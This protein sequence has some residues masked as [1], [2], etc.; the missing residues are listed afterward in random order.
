LPPRRLWPR[1][2]LTAVG[3]VV[4]F[5]LFSACALTLVPAAHAA[6]IAGLLP[7]ATA[8]MAVLRS[9]ER[10]RAAFWAAAL[11]GLIAVLGF[12]A[13]QG[14]GCP[15]LADALILI[16]VLLG[17]LGYAEGGALSRELGA[18]QVISWVLV[19]S[20]PVLLPVVAWR[21]LQIGLS[22]SPAA[23][24]GFAYVS[25][26][27]M[28]LGFFAWYYA[29]A[30]GAVAR[31]GQLQ[32]AQPVLTMLWSAMLLGERVTW[33]MALAAG[34]LGSVALTQRSRVLDR[35]PS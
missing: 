18:W 34:V 6:V 10:P 2:A 25:L 11:L 27:S 30:L 1:L 23:W 21:A 20:A 12:A 15:Q 24:L 9:G 8:V 3:V 19:L 7:T 16:A 35:G 32:L 4:G 31:I 17:G 22:A 26:V 14:I 5:P 29:L 33:E 28:Y 13:T